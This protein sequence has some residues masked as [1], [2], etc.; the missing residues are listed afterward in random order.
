MEPIPNLMPSERIDA[1]YSRQT[2]WRDELDE[3]RSVNETFN[4][5]CH[6][7]S[8]LVAVLLRTAL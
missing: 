6:Y 7:G 4:L 2:G 3:P 8:H 1:Q 5:L